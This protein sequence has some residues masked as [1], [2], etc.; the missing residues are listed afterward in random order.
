MLIVGYEIGH[1]IR[2]PVESPA[3]ASVAVN[4]KPVCGKLKQER[5]QKSTFPRSLS[6]KI[7]TNNGNR[8]KA[9]QMKRVSNGGLT[10]KSIV[11][12]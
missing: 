11:N 7:N 10:F 1:A 6:R 3:M 8:L 9:V 2:L 4:W 5:L 12:L